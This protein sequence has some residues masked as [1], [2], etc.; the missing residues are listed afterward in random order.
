MRSF[1]RK[2]DAGPSA[3]A[4][5][6]LID[7]R[8]LLGRERRLQALWHRAGACHGRS[9]GTARQ[10][11]V[12]GRTLESRGRHG[13]ATLSGALALR[14]GGGALYRQS[15]QSAAQF[16]SAHTT[17]S[18]ARHHHTERPALHDLSWRCTGYRSG[19]AQA[20]HPWPGEAS[21]CFY[22]GVARALSA[23]LAHWFR[24]M[25]RQQRAVVLERTAAGERA[26]AAWACLLR[27]MDWCPFIDAA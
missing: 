23:D 14:E 3:V 11:A 6:G 1:V 10:R 9:G 24:G 26:G 22:P 12:G 21:T 18:L 13:D 5:N 27:G 25:R 16:S 4:G 7:R 8:A 19:A 17:S 20:R 2:L 15:R